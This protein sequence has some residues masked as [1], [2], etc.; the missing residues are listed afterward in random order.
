[1]IDP[2]VM[3]TRLLFA[4]FILLILSLLVSGS[5][6]HFVLRQ[7]I[8]GPTLFLL[9]LNTF[10]L[11]DLFQ[12]SRTPHLIEENRMLKRELSLSRQE[13]SS[14]KEKLRSFQNMEAFL[15][16]QSLHPEKR[17]LLCRVIGRSPS[18]LNQTILLDGGSR[19][20]IEVD[21]AVVGTKGLVGRVVEVQEKWSK[22]LLITDPDA[23]V[24]AILE[25]SREGG[26]LIGSS[27]GLLTFEY[28]SPDAEIQEGDRVLTAGFG[29]IFP[30]GILIGE[31]IGF[32]RKEE[33]LFLYALVK[34]AEHLSQLEEV[35]CVKR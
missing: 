31:V 22:A 9:R 32:G 28:L 30:K 5:P 1:M 26:L 20:G 18:H 16:F 29:E 12:L 27:Q 21:M 10:F 4:G 2:S 3:K 14:L 15:S 25:R 35:L 23:K 19:E 34:P 11:N 13:V 6:A 8:T 17:G 33:T 7:G 24:G